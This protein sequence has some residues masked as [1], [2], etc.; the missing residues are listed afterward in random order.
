MNQQSALWYSIDSTIPSSV[1]KVRPNQVRGLPIT[2]WDQGRIKD[3][4]SP[5]LKIY[6]VALICIH[7]AVQ[8]HV[9]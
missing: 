2:S 1:S 5:K 8:K 9:Y 7:H 3:L 6:Y 4:R